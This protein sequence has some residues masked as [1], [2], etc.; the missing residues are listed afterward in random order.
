MS[1]LNFEYVWMIGEP[2]CGKTTLCL[3]NQHATIM[4]L[5]LR[6]ENPA[7]PEPR[8][9]LWP[10]KVKDPKTGRYRLDGP[11][12][13]GGRITWNS[14]LAFQRDM[15]QRA[16]NPAPDLPHT[17]VIDNLSTIKPIVEQG[18]VDFFNRS[19]NY[20]FKVFEDLVAKRGEAVW[21]HLSSTLGQYCDAFHDAGYGVVIVCHTSRVVEKDKTTGATVSTDKLQVA[22]TRGQITRLQSRPS[23]TVLVE[24]GPPH[25]V[26]R[27]KYVPTTH[28]K[29]RDPRLEG[30]L[31]TS[32]EMPNVDG[33]VAIKGDFNNTNHWETLRALWNAA[34]MENQNA[35]SQ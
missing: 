28:V 16:Q 5:D 32:I 6:T 27:G 29:F 22:L 18:V 34:S 17:I 20:S 31:K 14:L 1:D 2:G 12:L 25:M 8:A 7:I 24:K 13:E 26:E 19:F 30:L 9:K 15:I 11:H 35:D 23:L 33:T 4:N 3:Q 10:R 21:G